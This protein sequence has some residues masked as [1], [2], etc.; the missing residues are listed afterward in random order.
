MMGALNATHGKL[1]KRHKHNTVRMIAIGRLNTLAEEYL[2]EA[3]KIKRKCNI[4]G[5]LS[6]NDDK[7]TRHPSVMSVFDMAIKKAK[8][9]GF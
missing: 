6:F 3:I 4:I 9:D 2:C 1:T 7:K 8:K 5:L